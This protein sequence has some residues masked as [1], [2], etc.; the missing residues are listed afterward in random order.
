MLFK[1]NEILKMQNDRCK[2]SVK[3]FE[4]NNEV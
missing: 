4:I 3:D 1:D 2:D